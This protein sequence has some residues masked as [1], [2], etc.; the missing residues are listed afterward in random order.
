MNSP[1]QKAIDWAGRGDFNAV[2]N[3]HLANGYMW[4]G[5]DCFIMGRP[6]PKDC[7]E[8]ADQLIEWPEDICDVWF[9]FLGAGKDA[10]QRFLEVAPF[11]LPYVAWHRKKFSQ[12]KLKVWTWDQYNR[13][14]K[15][16]RR[17]ENGNNS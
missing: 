4:S 11:K 1:R 17:I 7:L 16:F 6:V 2:F 3:W 9:V 15:R 8:Y 14:T 13:V 10:L 12:D 5:R